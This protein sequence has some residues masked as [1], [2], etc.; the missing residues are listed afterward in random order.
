MTF[1]AELGD[2]TFLMILIYT[3]KMNNLIL[4]ISAS[5]ALALMHTLGSV[6]GGL[7]TLFISQNILTIISCVAFFI[8]GILLI[9]Q[10]VTMQDEHIDEK[11]KEVEHE[12]I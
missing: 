2:K 5:L 8:F 4:F 9:Y 6:T 1:L 11:I 12:V 10:G 3:A 7:F